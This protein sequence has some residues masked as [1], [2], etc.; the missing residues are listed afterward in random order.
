MRDGSSRSLTSV[1]VANRGEIVV[2]VCRTLAARGIR[3]SAIYTAEDA[4]ALHVRRADAA[5]R[6]PS[7]LDGRAVLDAARRAGADAV[8]PGYGFLSE[9]AAFARAVVEAGI[10]WIGPPPAAIEMMGDKIR[11]KATVSAAGVPV[12][13]GTGE[14]GLGDE[15]LAAAAREIG[16][17]VLVKPAAGGGGKGMRRVTAEADLGPAIAAARRE[18][19]GAFGDD[20]LL[21]ERWI[22]RPRH[23]E[24]QVFADAHGAVVHLGERECSLQ[25]RHQ[26]IVEE[27]PSPLLDDA[28]RLAMTTSA[29][30]AARACGYVGAGTVEFIVSGDRPDEYFFMEMNTRLQVEHPVTEAVTGIDLVDWQLRVAGGEPLPLEQPEIV[31]RGHAVEARVY[32]EDPTRQFLPATGT[33][34]LLH[35][36]ADRAHVRVDSALAEG[37]EVGTRYD[38]MLAKVVAWADTRAVA[39]ERLRAALEATTIL[40]VT[41]N[42][43]YLSRLLAHPDVVE[44]RLDTELVDRTLET[45]AEPPADASA[46]AAV[47]AAC[48]VALDLEPR[49]AEAGPWAVPDGWTICGPRPWVVA[50]RGDAGDVALEVR[51]SVTRGARVRTGE[52]EIDVTASPAGPGALTVCIDGVTETWAYATAGTDVWVGIAGS[53][54]H[55]VPER[56]PRS[57]VGTR[58]GGGDLS[59]P[60]PGV[61]V[62]VHV[63]S[64]ERVR[65][66]QALVAVEAMKME[67]AV[68]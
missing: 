9:D 29:T 27:T 16:L 48:A 66:G 4:G 64:G 42:T 19:A 28:T 22:G 43:G 36:P 62:A 58:P 67:H 45:L 50:L 49:G 33:V 3:S 32:A 25:R 12:V 40:G 37:V 38:P 26:K 56:A 15:E 2:R 30:D 17:P 41:T 61:V 35:E 23:I 46:R 60:M 7:Y 18:A 54:W 52:T 14:A 21:V 13:P 39:L 8:H 20:T 57:E 44:A 1:L 31:A 11:A 55:F 65:A 24:V 5:I 51:G 53:A 10:V 6:V 34:A 47:A 59:S 63:A 68:V